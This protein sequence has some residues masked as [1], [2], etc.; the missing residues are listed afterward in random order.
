MSSYLLE[1]LKTNV[2]HGFFQ[3]GSGGSDDPLSLCEQ[4]DPFP[5]MADMIQTEIQ[6]YNCLTPVRHNSTKVLGMWEL[7]VEQK[8]FS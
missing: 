4:S 8:S 6:V 1:N 7:I 2:V 3:G 5:N